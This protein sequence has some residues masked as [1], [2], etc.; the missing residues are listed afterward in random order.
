VDA[1]RARLLVD[2]DASG[3]V[4]AVAF[5]LGSLAVIENRPDASP[6]DRAREAARFLRDFPPVGGTRDIWDA[7]ATLLRTRFQTR[8]LG[9][10]VDGTESPE[11]LAA[12]GWN[13]T[14]PGFLTSEILLARLESM[15]LRE[16]SLDSWSETLLQIRRA[17]DLARGENPNRPEALA[18]DYWIRRGELELAVV[19]AVIGQETLLPYHSS[20]PRAFLEQREGFL[21]RVVDDA[22]PG[23][24]EPLAWLLVEYAEARGLIEWLDASRGDLPAVSDSCWVSGLDLIERTRGGAS[25]AE[26]RR[27]ET[28]LK[29]AVR[30]GGASDA[31]VWAS[32]RTRWEAGLR[33]LLMATRT[34]TSG[35]PAPAGS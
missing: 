18:R 32:P 26:D 34:R 12:V 5:A 24:A 30:L 29:Q 1:E 8:T 14:A 20:S 33:P 31:E 23:A 2:P 3:P 35:S 7:S 6:R 9:L 21:E 28:R 27:L 13:W 15:A 11:L 16:E 25:G 17:A 19:A 4:L 10:A 22:P